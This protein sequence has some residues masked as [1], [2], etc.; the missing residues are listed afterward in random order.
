M[1]LCDDEVRAHV[2]IMGIGDGNNDGYGDVSMGHRGAVSGH[3]F[4]VFVFL[5]DA[6]HRIIGHVAVDEIDV[7]YSC[8]CPRCDQE[9]W[10]WRL[11]LES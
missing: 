10:T 1:M 7:V 9:T 2:V 11:A 8:F 4:S 3:T 5:V 6:T